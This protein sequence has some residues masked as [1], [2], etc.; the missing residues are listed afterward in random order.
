MEQ[1][2]V[3]GQV[4]LLRWGVHNAGT[5]PPLVPSHSHRLALAPP[6]VQYSTG[7]RASQPGPASRCCH[8]TSQSMLFPSTFGLRLMVLTSV[9]PCSSKGHAAGVHGLMAG[10][11]PDHVHSLAGRR[12][13][14]HVSSLSLLLPLAHATARPL[15]PPA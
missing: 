10:M 5:L 13:T 9:F 1:A 6:S 12:A 3:A 11:Q 7:R 8:R 4:A 14:G 2:L 15:L